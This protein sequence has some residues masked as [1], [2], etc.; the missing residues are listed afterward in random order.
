MSGDGVSLTSAS[1]PKA[2]WWRRW[3]TQFHRISPDSLIDMELEV[4]WLG[5]DG[6]LY[7]VEG[8]GDVHR[9]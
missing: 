1:H 7:S 5:P 9:V 6:V 3:F 2:P 8:N 4:I